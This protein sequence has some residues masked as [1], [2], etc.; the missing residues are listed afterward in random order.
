MPSLLEPS[1]QNVASHLHFF[2]LGELRHLPMQIQERLMELVKPGSITDERLPAFLDSTLEA[3]SSESMNSICLKNF[4]KVSGEGMRVVAQRCPSLA[5][6]DVSYCESLDDAAIE[7]LVTNC[8]GLTSLNLS[9]CR[10]LSDTACGHI[11]RLSQLEELQLTCCSLITDLGIQQVAHCGGML[12]L[13]DLGSVKQLSAVSTM[14]IADHCTRLEELSIGGSPQLTD[15]D[16]HDICAKCVRLSELNLRACWRLTD[17]ALVAIGKLGKRQAARAKKSPASPQLV[18]LDLGGC[19]R[20]TDAGLASLQP[21]C[22]ALQQLDLRG[23]GKVSAEG[24]AAVLRSCRRLEQVNINACGAI[25]CD[26]ATQLKAARPDV[27][28]LG[29]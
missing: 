18:L 14:I 8:R 22:D 29:P 13:L 9:G 15:M 1:I 26:D 28:I 21:G 23:C 20:I 24:V 4:W 6:I 12:R 27:L 17:N 16:V 7:I 19:S 5:K 10:L 2:N 25:L 11:A 3:M